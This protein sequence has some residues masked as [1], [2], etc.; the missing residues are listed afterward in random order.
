MENEEKRVS[1]K[2]GRDVGKGLRRE[3][4]NNVEW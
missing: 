3:D 2:G 4:G 1:R